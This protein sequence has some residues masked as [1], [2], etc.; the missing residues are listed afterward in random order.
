MQQSVSMLPACTQIDKRRLP[1]LMTSIVHYYLECNQDSI[2]LPKLHITWGTIWCQHCWCHSELDVTCQSVS[3][4]HHVMLSDELSSKCE[5][6][7]TDSR[8]T[9][10]QEL[11][12]RNDK[13]PYCMQSMQQQ[14][15][16]LAHKCKQLTYPHPSCNRR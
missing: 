7:I 8:A 13:G 9:Q 15:R 3:H 14:G 6:E 4:W 11:W 10:P 5:R 12:R 1:L 16:T 2:E